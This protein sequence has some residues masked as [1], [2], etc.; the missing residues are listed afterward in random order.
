MYYVLQIVKSLYLPALVPPDVF[1]PFES[2]E[3]AWNEAHRKCVDLVGRYHN[4]DLVMLQN[5]GQGIAVLG[6]K[7]VHN[8]LHVVNLAAT[9]RLNHYQDI[10]GDI[11]F[12]GD[13]RRLDVYQHPADY[14]Y[15]F[16]G[17]RWVQCPVD[18][19]KIAYERCV[20]RKRPEGIIVGVTPRVKRNRALFLFST[21]NGVTWR[22]IPEGKDGDWVYHGEYPHTWFREVSAEEV[23]EALEDAGWIASSD[24]NEKCCVFQLFNKDDNSV[25]DQVCVPMTHELF[26]Y[27]EMMKKAILKC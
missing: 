15:S 22:H 24:E 26:D 17:I 6:T 11:L 3:D 23:C 13:R 18:L 21:D 2:F 4:P 8:E 27:D 19:G 25:A 1:G 5:K 16:D 10:Y 12:Q 9:E 14:L 7:D 20:Y